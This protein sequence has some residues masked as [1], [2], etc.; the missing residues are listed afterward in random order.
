[1]PD[2]EIAKALL[3]EPIHVM[4]RVS[5]I[6]DRGSLEVGVTGSGVA[7][8]RVTWIEFG[9]DTGWLDIGTYLKAHTMNDVVL[10]V[11]NGEYGGFSGRL[12]ISAGTEQYD[13]GVFA[14]AGCPCDAP[15]F[16]ILLRLDVPAAVD[17]DASVK[18]TA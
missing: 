2:R 6:D 13:S 16:Y 9:K 11:D 3:G 1:M 4:A 14:R 10:R 18:I 5:Q 15:A 7:G 12:E 8:Q 17:R